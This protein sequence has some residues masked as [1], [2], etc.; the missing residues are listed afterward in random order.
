VLPFDT[1]FRRSSPFTGNGSA[2]KPTFGAGAV[3]QTI[4]V[5]FGSATTFT[6]EGS[7]TAPASFTIGGASGNTADVTYAGLTFRVTQGATAFASGDRFYFEAWPTAVSYTMNVPFDVSFELAGRATSGADA[8]TVGNTPLVWGRQVVFERTAIAGTAVIGA[9]TRPMDRTVV[10][11]SSTAGLAVGDRVAIDDG[12]GAEEYLQIGRIQTTSDVA[13]FADLGAADRI[14]FTT[15]LRYAHLAG[16]PLRKVTLTGRREGVHYTVSDA[17]TGTLSLVPGAFAAG[18][19][20]VVSYRTAARFGWRRS[21]ADT[22]QAVFQP[23]A[24]DSADI[25]EE[26]GDWVGLSILPG[27]YTVGAWAHRDFSVTPS[28]TLSA[29]T[30]AWDDITTDDTT[31]RS[32]SPPATKKVLYGGATTIASRTIIPSSQVCETCH[33]SI[34]GHGNGRMG[35]ETCLMCHA[36]PGME[37]GPKYTF[38]AWYVPPTPGVTMDF[39][40]L[41]HKVHMGKELA[42]K[43]VFTMIGVFLGKPYVVTLEALGFSAMPGGARDCAVCHGDSPAWQRPTERRHPEQ[44]VPVRTWT[45]ACNGCHD[46]DS[47]GAHM[48][49]QTYQGAEACETCHGPGR[50]YSV[51]ISHKIW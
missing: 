23:A 14:H 30:R 27:T 17:A 39:R 25:G 48:A 12:Q 46:S 47:A 15:A 51:G 16:A 41:L 24:A 6:V 20:V 35:L 29:T 7:T 40:S 28:R 37:D 31:Y 36:T 42:K 5:V 33:D 9:P 21:A 2:S 50:E 3:A 26:A 22:L 45:N 38:A 1:G 34:Q 43:D 4:A 13:P 32:I 44:S 19:P 49:L 11:D 10:T 8:L 18:N